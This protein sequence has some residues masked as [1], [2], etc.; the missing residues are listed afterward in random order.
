MT[1]QFVSS[2][3]ISSG[4][5][6]SSGNTLEVLS[7]GTA[8]ATTVTSGGIQRVDVGGFASGTVISA[9]GSDT[10]FGTDTGAT[11]NSGETMLLE[12]STASAT[13]VTINSGGTLIDFN[14]FATL[15]N[16][17]DNGTLEFDGA[18]F[19]VSAASGSGVIEVTD[20][21]NIFL[22]LTSG[23]SNFTGGFV[24]SSGGLYGGGGLFLTSAGAALGLPIDLA[25]AGTILHIEDTAMPT[26][27]ISGFVPGARFINLD[28]TP[29]VSSGSA[30]VLAG[31]VLQITEGAVIDDLQLD[32]SV[33]YS[34]LFSAGDSLV[35]LYGAN[36]GTVVTIGQVQTVSS[37]S[38]IS[39]GTLSSG[40]IGEVFGTVVSTTIV[41]GGL[42][43]VFSGGTASATFIAAGM[44]SCTERTRTQPWSAARPCVS[45]PAARRPGTRS[46]AAEPRGSFRAASSAAPR[47]AKP[48]ALY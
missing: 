39:G 20:G 36:G 6:V 48:A 29:Y 21:G 13:N 14:H 34:A 25:G 27:T 40:I 44:R 24:L 32:P 1:T 8:D 38:V 4:V 43:V 11:V 46:V 7:G 18:G 45:S 2:G 41:P 31:N 35:L 16:I 9:G 12:R 23:S 17:V 10:V 3:V 22:S 30:A 15:S 47:L 28:A 33:N 42:G 19:N 26:D 5:I 37:G